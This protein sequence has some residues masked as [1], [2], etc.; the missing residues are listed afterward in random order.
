LAE[1]EQE[2]HFMQH[3]CGFVLLSLMLFG[4]TSLWAQSNPNGVVPLHTSDQPYLFLVRD[5]VVHADLQLST[6]DLQELNA[7]NDQIDM[8]MWSMRNKGPDTVNQTVPRLISTTRRKLAS[9]LT[10]EQNARIAQIELWVL[11]MR[12]LLRDD[13]AAQMNIDSAQQTSIRQIILETRK[14][15]A[16]LQKALNEGGDA[17]ALN[18]Q[19]REAQVRQ[20]EDIV[21]ILS[22]EQ[23]Q[24]WVALLG[25]RI[26]VSKLGRIKFKAPEIISAAG[27]VNSEPLTLEKLKGKVVAL[28]FYA[29]A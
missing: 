8:E 5:P 28:H 13:V 3:R 12:S 27:W 6:A 29:F 11:G 4:G 17:D 7:F 2:G 26:D 23:K 21:A 19:Y 1:H 10:N 16:E 25:K 20:Q 22:D 14:K 24:S 18:R 15:I 9:L